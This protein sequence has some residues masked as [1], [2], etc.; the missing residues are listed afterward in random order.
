MVHREIEGYLM[1][2]AQA[3][4][5]PRLSEMMTQIGV[6]W[7]QLAQGMHAGDIATSVRGD[8][9]AMEYD[10]ATLAAP[11]IL[12]RGQHL[13]R[14][15]WSVHAGR[16]ACPVCLAGDAS[17]RDGDR[18]PRA[19]HRNW[20]DIRSVTVCPVHRVK[21]VGYCGVFLWKRGH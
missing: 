5:V 15:Q 19:W 6:P 18:L 4:G 2:L 11:G 16:R 12:L 14:R 3:H 8:I 9:E 21:L 7:F 13:R 20:W 17:T 10:T 1:R